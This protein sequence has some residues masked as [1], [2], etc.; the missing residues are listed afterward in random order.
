MAALRPTLEELFTLH[1]GLWFTP[2]SFKGK[3]ANTMW[4]RLVAPQGQRDIRL[5]SGS[6]PL[7]EDPEVLYAVL[8]IMMNEGYLL[9]YKHAP[10]LALVKR[11]RSTPGKPRGNG[12]QTPARGRGR[13]G[14]GGGGRGRGGG[15]P[16]SQQGESSMGRG[17]T[18]A[19]F[20]PQQSY[21][22]VIAS[23][24]A[25]NAWHQPPPAAHNRSPAK[26]QEAPMD[27]SLREFFRRGGK[28][29]AT[30]ARPHHTQ[31]GGKTN[32]P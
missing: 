25:G 11:L 10:G 8:Q 21:R 2:L 1:V 20:S 5:L 29:L 16:A 28:G 31:G 30:G 26:E 6:R 17:G 13:R 23:N 9:Q 15:Q 32:H 19:P 24:A 14:R 3:P 27:S 4:S 18:A 7:F 12:D 22:Q